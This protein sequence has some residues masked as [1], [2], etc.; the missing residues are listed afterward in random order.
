VQLGL[1]STAACDAKEQVIPRPAYTYSKVVACSA[2]G[3]AVHCC[4]LSRLMLG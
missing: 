4:V 2:K 1:E 3:H